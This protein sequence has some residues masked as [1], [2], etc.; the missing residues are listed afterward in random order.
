MTENEYKE[1][2][3]RLEPA[4]GAPKCH[5]A[6]HK[7]NNRLAALEWAVTKRA[8]SAGDGGSGR[9]HRGASRTGREIA[10]T[11]GLSALLSP[12]DSTRG[13]PSYADAWKRRVV[14]DESEKQAD[15]RGGAR[16]GAGRKKK[17]G[18]KR[19]P[20]AL[21]ESTWGKLKR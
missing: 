13:S 10:E 11:E 17:V 2:K 15:C 7:L 8:A 21:R 12:G 5:R 19:R 14:Q 16:K 9:W 18:W 20:L 6:I 1:L 4:S 3:A